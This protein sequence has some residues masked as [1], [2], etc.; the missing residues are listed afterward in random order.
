MNKLRLSTLLA[1]TILATCIAVPAAAASQDE[2]CLIT[3]EE[4]TRGTELV[5][6]DVE[7]F[8][9]FAEVLTRVGA[10]SEI[11]ERVSEP[12][13]LT[14]E[15]MED[16]SP[17]GGDEKASA[18]SASIIGIHY[19][20]ASFSGSSF[21]VSG[22]NCSG[23]Y[24][25]VS[26]TWNNRVSSTANGCPTIRHY[27]GYNLIGTNQSTTGFGGNLTYMDNRTSSIQYT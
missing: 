18:Q 5:V 3:T 12:A 13:Q 24:L 14:A 6:V 11:R 9:T 2:H 21:S 25:N 22:S 17:G 1:A 15:D 8:R 26:S 7:C 4:P 10:S 23:G 19:D 27:D 20:G 16:L